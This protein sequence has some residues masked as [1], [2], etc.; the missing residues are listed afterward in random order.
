MMYNL[1][2][3]IKI[4][5]SGLSQKQYVEIQDIVM[6]K[7]IEDKYIDFS[8]LDKLFTLSPRRYFTSSLNSISLDNSFPPKLNKIII[9]ING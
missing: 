3:N 2:V 1:E 5:L 6:S 4:D 7:L 8:T 9:E